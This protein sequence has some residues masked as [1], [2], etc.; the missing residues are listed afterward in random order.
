MGRQC[1]A[2]ILCTVQDL[3]VYQAMNWIEGLRILE[4]NFI[5]SLRENFSHTNKDLPPI[6]IRSSVDL[7]TTQNYSKTQM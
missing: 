7:A 4:N 5:K 6:S 3:Q 1:M 2:V